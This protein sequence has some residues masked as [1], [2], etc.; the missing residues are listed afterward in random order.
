MYLPPHIYIYIYI[1]PATQGHSRTW[2][3][4][5]KE[6]RRQVTAQEAHET[7]AILLDLLSR[8]HVTTSILNPKP[9]P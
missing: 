8:D 4:S 7:V 9:D 6:E 5:N 1:Y 2:F 3:E